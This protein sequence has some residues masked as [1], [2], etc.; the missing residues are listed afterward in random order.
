MFTMDAFDHFTPSGLVPNTI[1]W[2]YLWVKDVAAAAEVG[3]DGH[4]IPPGMKGHVQCI[5]KGVRLAEN[6]VGT[7][8]RD[9]VLRML[10]ACVRRREWKGEDAAVLAEQYLGWRD[11]ELT[12]EQE[13]L[14]AEDELDDL[15]RR[16]ADLAY[17][18]DVQTDLSASLR[19]E[20]EELRDR[21]FADFRC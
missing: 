2:L 3:L 15:K 10:P 20:N 5:P 14:T 4:I 6:P 21:F 8:T 16:F 13:P 12:E 9:K 17:Q 11:Y 7:E 1:P 19:A 18:L